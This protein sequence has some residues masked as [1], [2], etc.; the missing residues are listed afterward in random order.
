MRTLLLTFF[1]FLTILSNHQVL[2]V[3]KYLFLGLVIRIHFAKGIDITLTKFPKH[4]IVTYSGKVRMIFK[5]K[6]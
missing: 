5:K 1:I 3:K 4:R 6:S 2:G